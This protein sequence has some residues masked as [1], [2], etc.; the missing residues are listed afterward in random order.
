MQGKTVIAIADRLSTIMRMDRIVVLGNGAIAGE[1]SHAALVS[2]DGPHARGRRRRPG[3]LIR[4][5]A[6]E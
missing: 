6:A 4:V 2:R 3:G 1:G 5:E